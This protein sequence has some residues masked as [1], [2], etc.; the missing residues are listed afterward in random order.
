MNISKANLLLIFSWLLF[1]VNTWSRNDTIISNPIVE[2]YFA[3]PTII[4]YKGAYYIYATID[5]WGSNELGVLETKDFKYFI[6]KHIEWPA[7]NLCTSPTSWGTMVWAPSV[8]EKGGKFYMYVS[9]GSEIWAGVSEH[10]LG[11]WKNAK[12]DNT[13]LIKSTLF[14]G[15]HMIDAECFIDD[16]GK[17]YIYWGSGLN[18][19]NG[20]CFVVKLKDDMISFDGPPQDITPPNYFEAPYVLKRNGIYY[21]M[22]SEGKAIDATYKIRYSTGKTPYGPWTEGKNSPII[23]TSNDSKTYGPGHNTVFI[24]NGQ[25]YI[26]YHRIFPQKESIVLRQLCLDSLNFDS[27]GNIK[28]IIPSGIKSFPGFDT[29][30]NGDTFSQTGI[31]PAP[32]G[33]D[34]LKKEIEHG[35]ILTKEY[36]S[37]T[38]GTIRKFMIYLPPGFSE[39]KKYPVLYLLLGIGGDETE[40]YKNGSPEIILDNLYAE[41]KLVPMIV[42]LPNGRA[43]QNDRAEGNMFNSEKVK[44]FENFEKDLLNDLIPFIESNYPLLTGP[45][46]RAIAGLSMGGGQSLNFGLA[47]LD[48]F[49][50]VGGFSP[51]PNT[52][53]PELLI[54]NPGKAV[55]K[56]KLLWISCGDQDNLLKI[57]R[58]MHDYLVKVKVPHTWFIEPGKHNFKVWK[59]DLYL[60]SQLLFRE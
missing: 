6:R 20:K 42:V 36:K 43:M 10:P 38:I 55:S 7:K 27:Q 1:A 25:Y 52:K 24:K 54:P 9:V 3:D 28:K 30:G 13:P 37:G 11:P 35:K 59:N 53:E 47:N 50:W 32:A 56:L 40:W 26:L 31:E 5:P 21:L 4:E 45:E 18:W 22:Y 49:S 48:T 51:A 41:K 19:V 60:F 16:D 23:S 17:A 8:K 39:G 33:F 12:E 15:Y 29:T 14:P 2:G 44:A 46:N 34:S 57:N 58:C